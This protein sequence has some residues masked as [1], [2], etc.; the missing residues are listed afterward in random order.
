MRSVSELYIRVYLRDPCLFYKFS[1]NLSCIID[2]N[3]AFTGGFFFVVHDFSCKG[4]LYYWYLPIGGQCHGIVIENQCAHLVF[5]PDFTVNI[6]LHDVGAIGYGCRFTKAVQLSQTFII[7]KNISVV[8]IYLDH[9]QAVLIIVYSIY[10]VKAD[11]FKAGWVIHPGYDVVRYLF[12]Q[13]I[14]LV[15]GTG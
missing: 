15:I 14:V 3:N 2:D 6:D 13:W 12:S 8:L 4:L 1:N 9:C 7:S 10:H 11:K 5:A